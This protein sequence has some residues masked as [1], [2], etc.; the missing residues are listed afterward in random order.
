MEHSSKVEK[1]IKLTLQEAEGYSGGFIVPIVYMKVVEKAVIL[2][3]KI[4]EWLTTE[5]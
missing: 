3:A 2:G 1:R 4:I 5:H